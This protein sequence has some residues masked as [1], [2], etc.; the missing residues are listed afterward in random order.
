MSQRLAYILLNLF[1]QSHEEIRQLPIFRNHIVIIGSNLVIQVNNIFLQ[2]K[3]PNITKHFIALDAVIIDIEFIFLIGAYIVSAHPRNRLV[4]IIKL[5]IHIN[6]G[7]V[8]FV[9]G[10]GLRIHFQRR[11]SFQ[12]PAGFLGSQ[13]F[14]GIQVRQQITHSIRVAFHHRRIVRLKQLVNLGYGV[15]FQR[16]V[17]HF[18]QCSVLF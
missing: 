14:L 13:D 6:I 11:K 2:M 17:R 9:L 7:N 8:C 16:Y 1:I 10:P 18:N 4:I 15:L 12:I 5:Q 3:L